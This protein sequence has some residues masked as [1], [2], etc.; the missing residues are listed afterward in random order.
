MA[1]DREDVSVYD[2][3]KKRERTGQMAYTGL[4]RR[5]YTRVNH[6]FVV[7][8]GI[9]GGIAVTDISQIR[10]ISL[11]GVLFTTS[12]VFEKGTKLILKIRLPGVDI[13]PTGEVVES[14]QVGQR[15]PLCDTRL[16]FSYM[17]TSD[18]KTLGEALDFYIKNNRIE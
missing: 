2:L 6:H 16:K 14:R 3:N 1:L 9:P 4:E 5:R 15:I 7:H 13:M 11:G 17:D 10:D 12:K 18:R 8:Y